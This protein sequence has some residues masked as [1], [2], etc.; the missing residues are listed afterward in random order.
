[1]IM[2]AT[3][4]WAGLLYFALPISFADSAYRER[5]RRMR[6][7]ATRLQQRQTPTTT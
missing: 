6:V 3:S 1:M 7:R 5:Q 4:W 2:L